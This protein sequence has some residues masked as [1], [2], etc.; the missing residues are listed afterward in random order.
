[1]SADRVPQLMSNLIAVINQDKAAPR[2]EHL[3]W[4]KGE[5]LHSKVAAVKVH[6]ALCLGMLELDKG[7]EESRQDIRPSFLTGAYYY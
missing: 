4:L 3:D 1:M 7:L 6:A 2:A 5:A